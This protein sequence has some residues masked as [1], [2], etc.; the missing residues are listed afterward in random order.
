MSPLIE[1]YPSARVIQLLTAAALAIPVRSL[2]FPTGSCIEFHVLGKCTNPGC[3]YKHEVLSTPMGSVKIAHV[4]AE[5][6]KGCQACETR[7]GI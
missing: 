6:T 2:K 3:A 4:V 1:R 7:G 5:L